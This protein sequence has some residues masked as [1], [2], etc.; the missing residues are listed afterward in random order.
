LG[1]NLAQ[2]SRKPKNALGI[3]CGRKISGGFRIE[4]RK[5]RMLVDC[6]PMEKPTNL[7]FAESFNILHFA[8]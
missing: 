3:F 4:L 1:Y 2:C 8:Y 5:K 6:E 7:E